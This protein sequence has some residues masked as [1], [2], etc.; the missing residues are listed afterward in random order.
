[1]SESTQLFEFRLPDVGEGLTEAEID[2]W[3]VEPGDE[4]EEGQPIAEIETDKAL[5]EIPS[6]CPAVIRE[7]T[8]APGDIAAVGDVIAV[9][10]A[11]NPPQHLLEQSRDLADR[12]AADATAEAESSDTEASGARESEPAATSEP[13]PDSTGGGAESPTATADSSD[14]D[15]GS[16]RVFAAPSTRRYASEHDVDL[17]NVEGSGPGGR[18]LKDDVD[19][20]LEAQ[21]PEPATPEPEPEPE[22]PAEPTTGAGGTAAETADIEGEGTL[23]TDQH[24][25]VIRRPLK[26]LRKT[27]ADN[28]ARSWEKVPRVTSGYSVPAE[29]LIEL[30]NNLDE[31]HD[32]HITYTPIMVKAVVPALQEFPM[33]NA[34]IDDEND[35]IIE[36]QYYN[37]GVAT[38]TEAGLIVPVIKDVDQKSIVEIAEEL[39]EIVEQTRD[40]SVSAEHLQGSTFTITNT[41]SH[42]GD[43]GTRG[44]FGTPIVNHPEVAILGMGRIRNEVVPVS[45]DEVGV[46]KRLSLTFAFDHRIIDGITAGQ[47]MSMVTSSIE[48]PDML[49]SRL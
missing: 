27:I 32:T 25:E 22:T 38:H 24:G 11:E 44:T 31:K 35:E 20:Y 19:A 40:R 45:D 18:I 47:F 9:L 33:V 26:G 48:D 12:E 21:S 15:S 41:G 17:A 43:S 8:V 28:M 37:I 30:K 7:L 3:L 16:D 42:G 49:L 34:T 13:E 39:N 1:M 36:K 5:V 46:E 2:Q 6:P 23:T 10:E 4:V 14:G 29:N